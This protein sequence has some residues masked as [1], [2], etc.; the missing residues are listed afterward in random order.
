MLLYLKLI[1]RAENFWECD[2]Q[3]VRIYFPPNRQQTAECDCC[4]H[5]LDIRVRS[6][7]CHRMCDGKLCQPVNDCDNFYAMVMIIIRRTVTCPDGTSYSRTNYHHCQ[8]P[9]C[10]FINPDL[11]NFV[12]T[13]KPKDLCKFANEFCAGVKK[14]NCDPNAPQKQQQPM[15]MIMGNMTSIASPQCASASCKLK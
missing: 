4:T 2:K 1:H 8:M 7:R 10:C 11:E 13:F 14:L 15:V 3:T 5:T 9:Y 6:Y 12:S